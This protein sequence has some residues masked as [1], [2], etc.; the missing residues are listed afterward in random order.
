MAQAPLQTTGKLDNSSGTTTDRQRNWSATDGAILKQDLFRLRS[1]DLDRK[2]FAAVRAD[3]FGLR[4]KVHAVATPP[5]NA[6]SAQ[7]QI[8]WELDFVTE[9]DSSS[10]TSLNFL[11]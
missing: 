8:Y 7:R 10:A 5:R 11:K 6:D 9:R 1:I 4:D 3:D 2:H